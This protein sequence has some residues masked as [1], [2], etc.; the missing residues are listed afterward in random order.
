MLP[1]SSYKSASTFYLWICLQRTHYS[2]NEYSWEYCK[3]TSQRRRPGRRLRAGPWNGNCSFF[4]SPGSHSSAH[5]F[6]YSISEYILRHW[7][8]ISYPMISKHNIWALI[9]T[10]HEANIMIVQVRVILLW[11]IYRTSDRYRVFVFKFDIRVEL[12]DWQ[13]SR[14]VWS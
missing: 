13:V 3:L 8:S 9:S 5:F 2:L 4:R 1:T 12:E 11:L 10:I 14:W 7:R 6:L